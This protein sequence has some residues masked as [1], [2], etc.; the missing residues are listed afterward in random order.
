M[1]IQFSLVEKEKYLLFKST[2]TYSF[3]DFKKLFEQINIKSKELKCKRVFL[4]FSEVIGIIPDLDRYEIGE[5]VAFT[6]KFNV[7]IAVFDKQDNV[8]YFAE[9]VAHNRGGN[10]R[11]F[12]N[13]EQALKWLLSS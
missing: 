3:V 5:F 7:K 6:M 13:K 11:I 10:M 1:N 2:D 9:T 4:D 8:N 12:T